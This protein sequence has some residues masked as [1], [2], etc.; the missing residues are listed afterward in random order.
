MKLS[1]AGKPIVWLAATLVAATLPMSSALAASGGEFYGYLQESIA[2]RTGDG[3]VIFHRQTI[4]SK[5]EVRPSR[6]VTLRFEADVWRDD[7][8]FQRDG[9]HGRARVREGYAKLRLGNADLRLGRV[10]IS[11][12]EA[13]GVIVS[14]Q[15][16]PFDLEN[17]IVAG[18]DEIRLGVDG[19]FLNYYFDSGN[20]IELL[21]IGHFESPDFPEPSSPWEFVD[22]EQLAAR[23]LTLARTERP[24][25]NLGNSEFGVRFSGH[26]IVADWSVGYLRSWD[27]RPSLRIRPPLV[28]PKHDM[29]DLFTANLVW[30]VGDVMLK[31]DGAYEHGRYLS[32]DPTKAGALTTAADGFVAKQDV[33]RTLVG[34]DAKPR[35]PGWREPN[36]SFQFVHEAVIDPHHSLLGPKNTDFVSILLTA[37]YRNE[38]IKPWLFAIINLRGADT[39]V[40]AKVDYEPIDHWRFTLE[41]DLFDGNPFDGSGGGLFG[42]FSNND[43][44]KT[45]I[46]YSY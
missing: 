25:N 43:M 31:F 20:E 22:P 30:P 36:A 44:V 46:R 26:P 7:A 32:T 33:A 9:A 12:G 38:T 11:W 13:D 6:D 39:W 29:F 37:S 16:S 35:V 14:D 19:A 10:Q 34:L 28:V 23:G 42:G 4:N 3:D 15:V 45:S 17:F 5:V 41:Y 2:F 24:A 21:W 40:Q 27:D 18:F 8:H 1:I